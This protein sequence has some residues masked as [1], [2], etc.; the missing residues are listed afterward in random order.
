MAVVVVGAARCMYADDWARFG[1]VWVGLM[2]DGINKFGA[3]GGGLEGV[4]R[5]LEGEGEGERM[6]GWAEEGD[7]PGYPAV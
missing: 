4:W 1:W 5:G 3:R 6:R 2:G 7:P